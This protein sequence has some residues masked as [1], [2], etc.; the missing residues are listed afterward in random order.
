MRTKKHEQG[1][2]GLAISL[3]ESKSPRRIDMNVGFARKKD[4][5]I[6]GEVKFYES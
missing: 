3:K 4:F 2:F 1:L 6:Y 5:L